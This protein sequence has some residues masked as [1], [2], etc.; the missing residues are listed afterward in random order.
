MTAIVPIVINAMTEEKICTFCVSVRS[1]PGGGGP[2]TP[3]EVMMM[4]GREKMKM[5]KRI[6]SRQP[7]EIG[8]GGLVRMYAKFRACSLV[9]KSLY[10]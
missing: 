8:G 4:L 6:Y 10:R 9:L 7:Q 3:V 2:K 1:M 5:K